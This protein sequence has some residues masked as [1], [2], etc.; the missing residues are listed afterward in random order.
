MVKE[1]ALKAFTL[2]P[3]GKE[4]IVSFYFRGEIIGLEALNQKM[5]SF[6][7]E[8]LTPAILC[9]ISYEKLLSLGTDFPQLYVKLLQLA[10]QRLNMGHYIS[11]LRA[12]Q[13]IAGFLLELSTRL[14]CTNHQ[15]G[16]ILP[17]ARQAI[18][19]YLGLA[20]E[21]VIRILNRLHQQEIITMKN[22]HIKVKDVSALL[23]L[24]QG[25]SNESLPH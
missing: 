21:T 10:S 8:S 19:D 3:Q 7:I 14:H 12:D 25:E 9:E 2:Q 5:Y 15:E 20:G 1:G 6:T 16:F 13:R 17:M 11:V 18:G 22:K 23:C 4:Q 24:A